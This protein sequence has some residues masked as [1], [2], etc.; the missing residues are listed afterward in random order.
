MRKKDEDKKKLNSLQMMKIAAFQPPLLGFPCVGEA[1]LFMIDGVREL[2]YW[3]WRS[4]K[5]FF[6][7]SLQIWV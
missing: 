2:K 4:G 3:T 1:I 6:E 7:V 5:I